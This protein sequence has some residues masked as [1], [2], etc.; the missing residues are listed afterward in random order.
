MKTCGDVYVHRAMILAMDK[1]LGLRSLLK[2]FLG[3][4]SNIV[5]PPAR[6][7][8]KSVG[9]ET[10]VPIFLFLVIEFKSDLAPLN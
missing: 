7:W 10:F 1:Q 5:E 8:R 9:V 2:A 6:E 4:G 3:L